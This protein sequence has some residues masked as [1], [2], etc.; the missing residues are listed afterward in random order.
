MDSELGGGMTTQRERRERE[1]KEKGK[2]LWRLMEALQATMSGLA[3]SQSPPA[4]VMVMDMLSQ[5]IQE[6][7]PISVIHS[8]HLAG[9]GPLP[10][11]FQT[12]PE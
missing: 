12:C 6:A 2:G 7:Q 3:G 4:S 1:G 10:L 8:R 9:P 5:G 11:C